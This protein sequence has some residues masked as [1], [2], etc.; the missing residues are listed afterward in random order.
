MAVNVVARR[1]VDGGDSLLFIVNV[2]FHR[3]FL[4]LF[5]TIVVDARHQG[6]GVVELEDGRLEPAAVN[7]HITKLFRWSG[8]Q[9]DMGGGIVSQKG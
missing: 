7:A 2:Q 9:S 5:A 6:D 3:H 1:N 4:H 8:N